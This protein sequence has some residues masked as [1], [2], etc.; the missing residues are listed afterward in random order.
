MTQAPV[1]RG[2]P[3]LLFVSACVMC[4]GHLRRSGLR[5]YANARTL[6]HKRNSAT[7]R[8]EMHFVAT[9]LLFRVRAKRR[10]T[11][12]MRNSEQ[13]AA[14]RLVLFRE[15]SVREP[16]FDAKDVL[17]PNRSGQGAPVAARHA[18]VGTEVDAD[19]H[20][21][22]DD[23]IAGSVLRPVDVGRGLLATEDRPANEFQDGRDSQLAGV[24][25]RARQLR[26]AHQE[27]ADA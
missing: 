1:K 14:K 22:I 21:C 5:T 11:A 7:N 9:C 26:L 8:D 4:A 19:S 17:V 2:E 15:S 10:W 27:V 12:R 20:L 23:G 6:F 16:I 25:L 3:A 13:V 18:V 24:G